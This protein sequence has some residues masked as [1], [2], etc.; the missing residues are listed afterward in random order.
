[1]EPARALPLVGFSPV[2]WTNP[3]RYLLPP[4]RRGWISI[5]RS[6]GSQITSRTPRQYRRGAAPGYRHTLLLTDS[7]FLE[8]AFGVFFSKPIYVPLPFPTVLQSPDSQ[9]RY[10]D[11]ARAFKPMQRDHHLVRAVCRAAFLFKRPS[12]MRPLALAPSVPPPPKGLGRRS[13]HIDLL[14]V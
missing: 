7:S 13:S 3:S 9:P 14:K 12:L 6:F 2:L 4:F 1:V 10:V 11:I 5:W 8:V